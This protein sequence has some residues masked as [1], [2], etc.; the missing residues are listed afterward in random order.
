MLRGVLRT[1]RYALSSREAQ[2]PGRAAAGRGVGAEISFIRDDRLCGFW[3][4][5]MP[6]GQLRYRIRRAGHCYMGAP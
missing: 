5:L 6:R 1:A 3:T 4:G 2:V